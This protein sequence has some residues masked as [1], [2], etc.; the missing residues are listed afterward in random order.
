MPTSPEAISLND[1]AEAVRPIAGYPLTIIFIMSK[2][3]GRASTAELHIILGI[4]L[5]TIRKHVQTA[6]IHRYIKKTL[7]YHAPEYF[8]TD[9]AFQISFPDFEK[10]QDNQ[11]EKILQIA[12]SSSI[13]ESLKLKDLKDL[14]TTTI[15][16]E[17][18]LQIEPKP[19]D[20]FEVSE[21]AKMLLDRIKVWPNVQQEIAHKFNNNLFEIAR[22]FPPGI[23]IPLCIHRV[24]EGIP[25]EEDRKVCPACGS[26]WLFVDGICHDSL[27]ST[28]QRG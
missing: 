12:P 11:S 27:C 17:R 20:G 21:E 19:W 16:S 24:R 6:I 4:S 26:H 10:I 13:K 22:W 7:D 5:P 1:L 14:T 2:L 25:P 3:G 15:R 18:I 9:K 8:L 23:D 28:N